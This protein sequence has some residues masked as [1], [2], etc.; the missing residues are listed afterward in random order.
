MAGCAR[1]FAAMAAM[2]LLLALGACGAQRTAAA[3]GASNRVQL[4]AKPP[5]SADVAT[6]FDVSLA[7]VASAAAGAQAAAAAIGKRVAACW[8]G[9]QPPD[10]PAVLLRVMLAQDGSV[11][12]VDVL[13]RK[14]FAADH[15]YHAAAATATAALFKCA[16]FTLPASAYADWQALELKFSPRHV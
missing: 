16:P 11:N 8:R 5:A 10:A 13:E 3:D 15:G 12:S 4:T 9:A 7:D 2:P 14:R 1:R 6:T